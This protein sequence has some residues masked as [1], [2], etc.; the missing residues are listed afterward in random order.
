M[1]RVLLII[2]PIII[3]VSCGTHESNVAEDSFIPSHDTVIHAE[4][5]FPQDSSHEIIFFA[6]DIYLDGR[7]Y[8][9]QQIKERF[10]GDYFIH[11]DGDTLS[12][13]GVRFGINVYD[14]TIVLITSVRIDDPQMEPVIRT[15]SFN[16]DMMPFVLDSDGFYWCNNPEYDTCEIVVLMKPLHTEKGGT[17]IIFS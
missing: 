12:I 9:L 6:E 3:G 8:V 7:E 5:Y 10:N 1:K 13:C 17:T 2:L 16:Y 15:I 14:E 11:L 4:T